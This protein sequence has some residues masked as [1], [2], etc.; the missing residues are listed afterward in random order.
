MFDHILACSDGQL[1]LVGG[2]QDTEG[3]VEICFNTTWGTVC[4]DAWGSQDASVV[5]RQ[6]GFSPTGAIATVRAFYG[7]GSG[8]IFLD[9]VNC[10]GTET[11]LV[12]CSANPIGQHN[13]VHA[14][15]AG[16]RCLPFDTPPPRK[17]YY[18]K[19]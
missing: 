7:A 14:E 10:G 13:C 2:P 17:W 19:S 11:R 12:N 16:V 18:R 9:N 1:R 3:R 15:D 8:S 6:L 5:C 4:D